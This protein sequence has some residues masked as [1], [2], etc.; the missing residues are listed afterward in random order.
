MMSKPVCIQCGICCE[1]LSWD[2]R[3]K[4]SLHT[5]SI[6]LSRVCRFLEVRNDFEAV[7]KIEKNKPKVCKDFS[8]GVNI[9]MDQLIG[10]DLF[11]WKEEVN[12]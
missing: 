9:L 1:Q 7:C 10:A 11:D 2:E 3:L 4:I 5:K 8:C 6:M 12:A